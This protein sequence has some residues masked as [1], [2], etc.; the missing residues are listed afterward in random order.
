MKL[1][2]TILL[3]THREQF[4]ASELVELLQRL[5]ATHGDHVVRVRSDEFGIDQLKFVDL[6]KIEVSGELIYS[7]L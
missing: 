4:L 3:E 1:N 7:L 6:A 5:I 2:P